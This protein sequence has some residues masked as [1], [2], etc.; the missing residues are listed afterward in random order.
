LGI[1][2]VEEIRQQSQEVIC[3]PRQ[4]VEEELAADAK[5]QAKEQETEERAEAERKD[6]EKTAKKKITE[7][8]KAYAK[9]SKPE[10]SVTAAVSSIPQPNETELRQS[11]CGAEASGESGEDM[12]TAVSMQE[13]STS[14]PLLE[15]DCFGVADE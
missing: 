9:N 12:T 6:T 14:T 11:G 1:N 7:E 15:P 2:F 5:R 4:E 8:K 3:R 13:Q 10:P